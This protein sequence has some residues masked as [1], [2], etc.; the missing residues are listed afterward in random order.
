MLGVEQSACVNIYLTLPCA[1]RRTLLPGA[2]F[3]SLRV[4]PFNSA[5]V[6]VEG[7]ISILNSVWEEV[8]LILSVIEDI[9]G[10]RGVR[11][12][13]RWGLLRVGGSWG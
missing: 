4:L 6:V 1:M 2:S 9:G 3:N 11:E 5:T 13:E 12:G 7:V 10:T 8:D